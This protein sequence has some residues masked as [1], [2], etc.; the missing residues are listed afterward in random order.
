TI[1]LV[2][3]ITSGSRQA[4]DPFDQF[5]ESRSMYRKHTARDASCLFRVIA[6]QMYDTQMLHYEVRLECVRFMTR[7]RRIFEQHVRGDFDSYML[8]MAKPKTYGT[9]L[10][11]RAL[12]CMYRR[13]VILFEPYNLGTTVTYSERYQDNFRVFY[14]NEYHFDSVY[15]LEYIELAAICQSISFKLLYKMLFKIPDVNFAVE[16][17]LHPETFDWGTYKVEF[18]AWGYFVRIVCSDG[19]VFELDLPEN[20]KCVLENYKLCSFHNNPTLKTRKQLQLQYR[21]ALPATDKDSSASGSGS[22]SRQ[23]LPHESLMPNK[24]TDV[25]QMCPHLNSCVRQLLSDGI[26]PFPYK[27][28]KSLDPYMYRNIEFDTWSDLRKEAKRYNV[29]ANDYN[30]KVGAKCRVEL[31][32]ENDRKMYTCHIQKIGADKSFCV[33][34]V[35]HFG[36]EC[37]VPYESLHPMPPEEFQPWEVPFR[38]QRQLQHVHLGKVVHKPK[39][40]KWKKAKIFDVGNY[41][42]ASKCEVQ[43]MQLDTCY[44]YP[45]MSND[46]GESH[47]QHAHHQQMQHG[48]MHEPVPMELQQHQQQD[49]RVQSRGKHVRHQLQDQQTPPSATVG[50]PPGPALLTAPAQF[51]N[52]LPMTGRPGIGPVPPPWPGTPMPM[53]EEYPAGV[54]PA[55]PLAANGCM[56]MHFG[57]YMPPPPVSQHPSPAFAASPFMFTP[58]LPM[59]RSVMS[60]VRRSLQANGEDLPDDLS[61]LRYFYNIGVDAHMRQFN[62]N[63]QNHFNTD[64]QHQQ[65]HQQQPP[66][67]PPQQQQQQQQPPQQPQHQQPQQ[68]QQQQQQLKQRNDET[69]AFVATSPATSEVAN[70]TTQQSGTSSNSANAAEPAAA[71]TK[72]RSRSKREAFNKGRYKRPEQLHDLNMDNQQASYAVQLLTPSPTPSPSA[73]N[74]QFNFYPTAQAPP[75]TQQPLPLRPPVYFAHK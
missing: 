30:F 53:Q 40:H 29:Y 12:C 9:M 27:V 47:P 49:Q 11:L 22:S 44:G 63:N 54:F 50:A 24:S 48:V 67:P 18:D 57:G 28:A 21:K 45:A 8:D 4:P 46:H 15:T 26:T 70:A 23:D 62:I 59:A 60:E 17:M 73:N 10:E 71:A 36:K 2:R 14:T 51:V 25:L 61:T 55:P 7:K 13:N 75:P 32:T 35:E 42:E 64:H 20:T 31:Q 19:R 16:T 41:F 74:N 43:Y 68:Q 34:F 39:M 5:L 37:M 66:P 38:Y 72:S 58:Q 33:V 52:Y 1:M 6:E 69:I 3:P 56:L 65:Q